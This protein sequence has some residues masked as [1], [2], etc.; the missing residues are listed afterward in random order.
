MLLP[1]DSSGSD[2]NMSGTIGRIVS[3]LEGKNLLSSLSRLLRSS[4]LTFRVYLVRP[5]ISFYTKTACYNVLKIKNN[6][7]SLN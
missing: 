6:L 7:T 2:T 4:I 3:S 1:V 5:K